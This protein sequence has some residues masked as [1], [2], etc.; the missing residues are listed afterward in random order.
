[1]K[2]IISLIHTVILWQV[3]GF[4]AFCQSKKVIELNWKSA[5]NKTISDNLSLKIIRL[6]LEK[7]VYEEYK[8][9]SYFLPTFSYQGAMV[10]NLELPT[11]IIPPN[12]LFPF[13]ARIKFGLE[14]TFQHSFQFN[15][16]LFVGFSRWNNYKIQNYVKKSLSEE[17]KKQE[18][19]IVAATLIAY[20]GALLADKLVEANKEAL[21]VAKANYEQVEKFYAAGKS[22]ELDLQRAKSQYF[23][24]IPKYESA[25][26]QK[27]LAYQNLKLI[28]NIP[29]Q[30]SLILRDSLS[31]QNFG[32]EYLNLSKDE[33]IN[34]AKRNR[35]EIKSLEYNYEI[36]SKSVDMS[37]GSFL[38]NVNA[39]FGIQH[40]AQLPN[41]KVGWDDYMR[42]K[43]FT[44]G[45]QW[46]LFE[47]GRKLINYQEAKIN[48]KKIALSK[49]A[50][51]K[52]IELEVEQTYLAIVESQKNL[53]SLE[54]SLITA[55]ESLRLSQLLYQE[56]MVSQLDVLNAQL[57][58]TTS[59]VLYLQGIYN[60]TISR[61]NFLKAIGKL[62]QIFDN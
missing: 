17:L 41:S 9:L 11:T 39:S 33:L 13:G 3:L 54:E 42:S 36:A 50:F 18:Q 34:I 25:L 4:S 22:A 47:G 45:A 38:P 6:D 7:Q 21:E 27:Y 51:D 26:N 32:E 14:Y 2:I 43:T 19:Q 52:Q 10:R 48:E 49:E 24:Q 16:P 35:P 46:V 40:M 20:Y 59:Y 8:S 37:L 53:K 55:K 23:S 28:L 1:M 60:Y 44:I 5:V 29:L 31:L 57:F 56:G 15:Y 61:I 12:P 58:Y 30:D 62:N